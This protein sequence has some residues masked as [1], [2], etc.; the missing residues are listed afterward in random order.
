M[1]GN[2]V[3]CVRTDNEKMSLCFF[4]YIS[5]VSKKILYVY[6]RHSNTLIAQ[7]FHFFSF[8]IFTEK[9]SVNIKCE[10]AYVAVTEGVLLYYSAHCCF[11]FSA[12]LCHL[13]YLD[14]SMT[15]VLRSSK[16]R[17]GMKRPR[18]EPYRYIH[19]HFS[20]LTGIFRNSRHEDI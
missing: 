18:N 15:G 12:H 19:T 6:F 10:A 13:S 1:L 8:L 2:S 3:I 14:E 4:K 17:P 11:S 5:I 20:F 7:H 16:Q 9:Q